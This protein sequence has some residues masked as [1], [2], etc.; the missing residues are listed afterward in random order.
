MKTDKHVDEPAL[1]PNTLVAH[2]NRSIRQG[3]C[4]TCKHADN[5][6]FP[7]YDDR[8][9]LQCEEFEGETNETV[10]HIA[11]PEIETNHERVSDKEKLL[12]LCENCANRDICTFEKPEGGV[13][14]CEE[15]E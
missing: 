3:L 14:R 13:W 8:P 2:K 5:C 9:V 7:L 15:Y 11:S 6:T 1:V 4:E 12:G 10:Q